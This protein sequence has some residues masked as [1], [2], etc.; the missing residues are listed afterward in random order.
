MGVAFWYGTNLVLDGY[1]RF[2]FIC[3]KL[4]F[5]IFSPGTVFACFWAACGGANRLG[6]AIPQISVIMQA[7]M[8]AGEILSMIDMVVFIKFILHHLL[9]RNQHLI[10]HLKKGPNSRK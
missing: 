10:A 7:K 8:A 9:S 6:Q 4:I 1:M 2:V 5:Y 3:Y